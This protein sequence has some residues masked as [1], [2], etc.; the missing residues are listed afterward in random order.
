MT[1]NTDRFIHL[2]DES[3]DLV[4]TEELLDWVRAHGVDPNDVVHDGVRI[5]G[6]EP[7]VMFE[8]QART[9]EGEYAFRGDRVSTYFVTKPLQSLPGERP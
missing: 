5:S 6:P 4:T 3:G 7:T 9:L 8:L 1:D 2:I